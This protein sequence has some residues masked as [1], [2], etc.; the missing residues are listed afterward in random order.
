MNPNDK[1]SVDIPPRSQR[2]EPVRVSVQTLFAGGTEVILV[3][4][5]EDY[6]LRITSRGKLI[7]TK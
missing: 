3:H 4:N 6:R 7:L 2:S 5:E 1:I